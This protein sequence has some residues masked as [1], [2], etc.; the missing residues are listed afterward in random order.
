MRS[1]KAY[2]ESNRDLEVSGD[3]D[4]KI[5]AGFPVIGKRSS[6]VFFELLNKI[7]LVIVIVDF[8]VDIPHHPPLRSRFDIIV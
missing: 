1:G 8:L 4:F 7:K 6:N 3:E 5:I 2:F